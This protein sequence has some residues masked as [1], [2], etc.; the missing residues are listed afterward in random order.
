MRDLVLEGK[1][2]NAHEAYDNML[3]DLLGLIFPVPKKNQK[4]NYK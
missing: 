4:I 3:I 2:Y 1:K